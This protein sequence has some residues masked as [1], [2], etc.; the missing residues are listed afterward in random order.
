MNIL[1]VDDEA[2][3]RKGLE[4]A[5][6]RFEGCLV[7][8]SAD[9]GETA[10]QWLEQ[11]DKLPD[12]MITDIFMQFIDGLELIEQVGRLYPDIKCAILSGHEEFHLARKAIDLKVCRYISKPVETA[13][14]YSI[15]SEIRTEIVL[16]R[17]RRS[18]LLKMEKLATHSGYYVRDKLLL[19]LLDG[20]LV[21]ASELSDFAGCFPFALNEPFIGGIIRICKFGVDLSARDM[22]LYSVAVKQLFMEAVLSQVNGFVVI[23]DT[24]TLVYGIAP[25]PESEALS[26]F[27]ALSESVLGVAVALDTGLKQRGLL[28]FQESV[29]E[30]AERLERQINADYEYPHEQ[31]RSLRMLLRTGGIGGMDEAAAA[32]MRRLIEKSA[33]T[34]ILYQG[35]YRL[36]ASVEAL[37]QELGADCPKP[38]LLTQHSLPADMAKV[39]R[40]LLECGESRQAAKTQRRSE[41]VDRVVAYMQENYGEVSLSLQHLAELVSVHPNYLTQTFRKHTGLSCIQYLTRMRMEKAKELLQHNELKIYEIAERVGYENPLYFSSYFK[42]WVGVHPTGYKDRQSEHA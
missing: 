31:E 33:A 18:D 39:E 38:P 3:I 32:F 30:A 41:L 23:K 9:D 27:A 2:I 20:R 40:W 13:E 42:K 7:L 26:G 22:L 19:D 5:I 36:V 15:L 14:L 34:A 28:Q 16:E 4:K 21:S 24:G 6:G 35:C 10:L 17:T 8:G 25:G 37:F 11:A 1:I 29:A 12:L